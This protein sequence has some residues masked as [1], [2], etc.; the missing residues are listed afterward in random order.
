[1]ATSTS[2]GLFFIQTSLPPS[3][4]FSTIDVHSDRPI[5]TAGTTEGGLFSI[6][7]QTS[8]STTAT[9]SDGGL[10]SIETQTSLSSTVT[11][12]D[13]GLFSIETQTSLTG[14]TS[15]VPSQTTSPGINDKS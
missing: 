5:P 4:E 11:S 1:M 9:G 2:D 12:S 10:F 14:T 3:N 6:E 7:T 15:E 8:L 13:G